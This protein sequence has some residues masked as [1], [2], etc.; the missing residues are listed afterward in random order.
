MEEGDLVLC[1]VIKIEGT[2]VFV[3]LPT[4]EKGAIT[5]SEIAP[6]RIRN[7]R[8]YVVPKKKIVCKVLRIKGD[9][10]DLSLRRV[11]T[12]ERKE[13]MQKY[14]QE[15]T[16]KSALH[17]IVKKDLEETEQKILR[18]FASI[19]DFLIQAREDEKLISKYIPKP[20]QEQIKKIT[21]K[22][23]KQIEA[24]KIIKLKCLED[25]GVKKIKQVLKTDNKEAKITYLSAGKFQINLKGQDYK[26]ANQELDKIIE[27]IKD[28]SKELHCEF[29]VSEKSK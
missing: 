1:T 29:E 18:D 25:D 26:Q 17:S 20:A 21:Q 10:I 16:A 12:K 13:V 15:Q 3:H 4:G 5:T 2:T 24:K 23:Q 9:H 8:V 22:K 11:N 6:G 28:K 7:I 14:K 19:S 27:Q